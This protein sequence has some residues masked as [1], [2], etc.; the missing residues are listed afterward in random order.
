MFFDQKKHSLGVHMKN[1]ILKDFRKIVTSEFISK[2]ADKFKFSRRNT[3]KISGL[4]FVRMLISHLGNGTCV[5]YSGLNAALQKINPNIKISNQ[6][7]AKYF[8]KQAS[9]DL[10]RSVYEKILLFQKDILVQNN[11]ELDSK[12]FWLFV[13]LR[14]KNFI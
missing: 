4:D 13:G 6:A 3:S 1:T 2:T 9:V 5:S 14:G 10:I 8:Y 7:L 11:F 12:M